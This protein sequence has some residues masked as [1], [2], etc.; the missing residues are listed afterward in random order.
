MVKVFPLI[1]AFLGLCAVCIGQGPELKC[2]DVR[3][4]GPAGIVMPGEP[5]LS[6]AMVSGS[7][8]KLTYTWLISNGKI[9]DGQGTAQI[10][11]AYKVAG[12]PNTVT[13]KI[14]G[15]PAN[16][17]DHASNT[18]EFGPPLVSILLDRYGRGSW[19]SERKRINRWKS[20]LKRDPY[21]QL[22]VYMYV[23][24]NRIAQAD[25][26]VRKIKEVFGLEQSRLTFRTVPSKQETT[27][28][29]LVPAG[30]ENPI[31]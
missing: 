18:V 11:S 27:K 19:A 3:V 14:G 22:N 20:E 1:F 10:R 2:P 21:A 12:R 8:E 5:F 25:S 28:V 17:V 13:V 4:I 9:L 31:P 26:R 23:Q 24:A 29:Y 6:R 16:C 30:A 15:L 7:V